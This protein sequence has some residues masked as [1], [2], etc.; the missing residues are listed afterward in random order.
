MSFGL[1][2]K[3][4][5]NDKRNEINFQKRVQML[6]TDVIFQLFVVILNQLN[7]ILEYIR[8]SV[9]VLIMAISLT[10]IF[11]VIHFMKVVKKNYFVSSTVNKIP[12]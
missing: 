11:N 7:L 4:R 2:F 6:R 1:K 9:D 8:I 5:I 12:K 3:T 10:E